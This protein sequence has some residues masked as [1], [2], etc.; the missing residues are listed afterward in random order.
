M[1]NPPPPPSIWGGGGE[2][3]HGVGSQGNQGKV[4]QKQGQ[5]FLSACGAYDSYV[6]GMAQ[7]W[8][9]HNPWGARFEWGCPPPIWGEGAPPIWGEGGGGRTLS[10]LMDTIC[11]QIW[12]SHKGFHKSSSSLLYLFRA[13]GPLA[14]VDYRFRIPSFTTCRLVQGELIFCPTLIYP[15][16]LQDIRSAKHHEGQIVLR[17]P[18]EPNG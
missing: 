6:C 2:P 13:L 5:F 18:P 17:F 11:A 9:F 10:T 8:T 16:V 7:I 14:I 3:W 12:F 1:F 15:H 4:S